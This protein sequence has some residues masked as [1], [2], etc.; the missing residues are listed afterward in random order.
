MKYTIIIYGRHSNDWTLAFS[1]ISSLWNTFPDIDIQHIGNYCTIPNNIYSTPINIVIPLMETHIID[2]IDKHHSD[3]FPSLIPTKSMIET[4][5][6]KLAFSCYV[7]DNNLS[8]MTPK[9]Y[10]IDNIVYPCII[11]R[12][13][14]NNGNGCNILNNENDLKKYLNSNKKYVIQN[15]IYDNIEYTTHCICHNGNILWH[16]TYVY[17]LDSQCTIK[18]GYVDSHKYEISNIVLS[19]LQ[20]FLLPIKYQGPCN[21]DYKVIDGHIMVMEI[22]PR[23]GGSLMIEDNREDLRQAIKTIID[24]LT[25]N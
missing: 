17:K 11:K 1:K 20:S 10:T 22:N 2:F 14:L 3:K 5:A 4:F 7:N 6:N 21:I 12:T 9:I 19:E 8:L 13:N 23:F 24:V 15:I 16:V 25:N 18:K